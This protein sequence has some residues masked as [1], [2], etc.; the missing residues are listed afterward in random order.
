MSRGYGS[1]ANGVVQADNPKSQEPSKKNGKSG[2][3]KK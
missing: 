3:S 2:G 1:G